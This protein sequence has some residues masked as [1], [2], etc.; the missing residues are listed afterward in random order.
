MPRAPIRT[1]PQ[2]QWFTAGPLVGMRDAP[3]PGT[4][5]PDRAYDV[6]N[7][8][9]QPGPQGTGLVGRPGFTVLGEVTAAPQSLGTLVQAVLTWTDANGV[10]ITTACVDGV[11]WTYNWSTDVWTNVVTAG[12]LVTASVTLSTTAPL[13]SLVPFAGRLMISDGVNA[14]VTWT[15]ATG[16]GGV[17]QI[18]GV[19][20]FFGPLVVYYAKLFGVLLNDAGAGPRKTLVWSEENDETL[21]YNIAPYNNAW[22]NPGAYTEP[23]TACAATNDALFLFRER[24]TIAITGAVN[25]DFQ[26]AGTRAN[27]SEET[28][29]VSPWAV[30]VIDQGVL[31]VDQT[32]AVHLAQLGGSEPVGLWE[33]AVRVTRTT[34]RQSLGVATTI[35]DGATES[36][37]V[38]LPIAGTALPYLWLCYDE[39]T[40]AFV[41]VWSWDRG[42][43]TAGEVVDGD[44]VARWAHAAG[45]KVFG[46]GTLEGPYA[47]DPLGTGAEVAITHRVTGPLQ[48]YDLDEELRIDALEVSLPACTATEVAL[49]YTTPRGETVPQTVALPS[50]SGGGFQLDLSELDVGTLGGVSVVNRKAIARTFGRGRGVQMTV[51][52]GAVGESF[53]VDVLRVRTYRTTG[54]NQAP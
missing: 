28:G 12:N 41:G 35:R 2:A 3:Q 7:L 34:P 40:L 22:D 53:A 14:L 51:Q 46:H 42:A 44:G 4:P 36:L 18:T 43:T 13:V 27:V 54:N 45:G 24:R 21:G 26:T 25:S 48:G 20:P 31:F 6:R 8:C 23:L 19:G 32:G 15:G 39:R 37:L 11:L 33:D 29:T 47:D 30:R 16:A 52:H 1:K 5:T 17:D 50:T 49:G 38:G 9:R 10:R